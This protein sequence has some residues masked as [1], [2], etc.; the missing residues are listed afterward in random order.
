MP[1]ILI[2]AGHVAP[3]EPGKESQTGTKREQEFASKMQA[4]LNSLFTRDGR[5]AVTLC[6]GDIPDGWTGDVFVSL[7]LDGSLDTATRGYCF[8]WPANGRNPG[9]GPELA[10]RITRRFD[11]IPHHGR[12]RTDN[13]TDGL[14][15]YYGWS[16]VNAP[17]KVLIEHGF[18]TNPDELAWLFTHIPQMAL[19]TYGAV[20]EHEGLP[21]GHSRPWVA[22]WSAYDGLRRIG[23]GS[24]LN[25]AFVLRISTALR[26]AGKVPP[27]EAVV[28]GSVIA[29]GRLWPPGAFTRS[30]SGE[31]R[32]GRDVVLNGVVRLTK[33]IP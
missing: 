2:Q 13:Y 19:A 4:E 3:R 23:R 20:V 27:W 31:L 11:A 22:R 25:P 6:P 17:T 32:A 15:G 7:H 16:R 21:S 29:T 24:L 10:A 5:W 12:H 18:A 30:V 14:R 9:R 28:A 8:G 33:E 26:R 1:R